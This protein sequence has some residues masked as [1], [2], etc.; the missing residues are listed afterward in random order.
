MVIPMMKWM[1]SIVGVAGVGVAGVGVVNLP[2]AQAGVLKAVPTSACTIAI[3]STVKQLDAV[4]NTT[5]LAFR[6][7]PLG[8]YR[9]GPSNKLSAYHFVFRGRGGEDILR[10]P[11]M[12]KTLASRLLQDCNE[13][14]TVT[15]GLDQSDA[16]AVYGVVNGAVQ[17]FNCYEGTRFPRQMPWGQRI[18]L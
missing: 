15:F 17:A 12:M 16:F 13:P 3:S 5:G 1:M 6:T 18:C 11:K 14:G 4:P 9:G 7:Y 10:S 2:I 8:G